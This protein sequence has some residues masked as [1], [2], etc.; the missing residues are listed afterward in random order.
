MKR[1]LQ[2]ESAWKDWYKPLSAAL[3]ADPLVHFVGGK[4]NFV[5]HQDMLKPSSKG[6]IGI[7]ELRGM[8]LGLGVSI[9]PFEDSDEALHR[10][11]KSTVEHGDFLGILMRDEDSLP[12]VYREWRLK[13]FDEEIV[14]LCSK[15]W[16]RT[17][18][19]IT[20]SLNFLGDKMPS[21]P[22]DCGR[23][24]SEEKRFQYK[25]YDRESLISQAM[26]TKCSL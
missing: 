4:R 9:S 11:L 15:A 14:A 8:K 22:L 25:L 19:N 10:Y 23:H 13:E 3:K 5:V 24:Q 7:T 18:E 16:L 12:C 2:N 1:E 20:A 6:S 17:G 26:S 21:F